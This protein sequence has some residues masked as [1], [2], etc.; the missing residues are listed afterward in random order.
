M[1]PGTESKRMTLNAGLADRQAVVTI[2]GHGRFTVTAEA[3]RMIDALGGSLHCY[4]GAGG[5][6]VQ[7]LHFSRTR[8]KKFLAGVVEPT[9]DPTPAV[10]ITISY[11]LAD[12]IE[13]AVLDFGNYHRVQRFVWTTMPAV[14][15][16]R[17]TCLRS[18]GKPAGKRS[19]C[20]DDRT[21]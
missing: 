8:P 16:P 4:Q 6:R 12:R 1:R 10:T 13:G 14:K 3:L 2:P 7:G 17:C 21:H 19:P 9:A 5:C 18:M 15:G 20:L 11:D